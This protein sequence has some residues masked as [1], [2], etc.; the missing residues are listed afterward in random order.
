[1]DQRKKFGF[2]L[3]ELI[4]VIAILDV[5]A[6]VAVPVYSGYV[7]K[8]NRAADEILL[9]A[10]N[11]AFGAACIENG[12]DAA[13]IGNNNAA[14]TVSGEKITGVTISEA[15]YS[16]KSDAVRS[17]F[18]RYFGPEN[19]DRE[20]KYY[21]SASDFVFER[22]AFHGVG[23]GSSKDMTALHNAVSAM[24]D[25]LMANLK[26]SG[27]EGNETK[28]MSDI[29]SLTDVAKTVAENG[30][31]T[32]LLGGQFGQYLVDAGYISDASE[33]G[34]MDTQVVSNAATLM[35][36]NQIDSLSDEDEVAL[37]VSWASNRFPMSG[38]GTGLATRYSKAVNGV[39]TLGS[40]A[41]AY[42]NTEAFILYLNKNL[43]SSGNSALA[44]VN[45]IF[46]DVPNRLS[47][48]TTTSDVVNVINKVN[49][50]IMT[51]VGTASDADKGAIQAALGSYLNSKVSGG[52]TQA[53][54]DAESYVAALKTINSNAATL[55]DYTDTS[56]LYSY[57]SSSLGD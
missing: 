37:I 29:Q 26:D 45:S 25:T 35:V 23:D 50:D 42:A 53:Q 49:D 13:K 24:K 5:L 38:S 41:T 56:G 46:A 39:S 9:D 32:A 21:K 2:T 57:I 8:A 10:V 20:L 12:F 48:A 4:V 16:A 44:S 14:L 51:T 43:D 55:K 28:L 47:T 3:V 7:K 15:A 22:G 18:A 31:M 30:D 34:D 1:M 27:F 54:L 19:L 52:K 11:T 33:F 36:A 6:G 17:S 40:V